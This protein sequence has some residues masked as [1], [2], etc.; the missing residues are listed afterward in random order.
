MK[1]V[2]LKIKNKINK[3]LS[4]YAALKEENLFLISEKNKLISEI[5]NCKEKIS[6][7]EDKIKIMSITKS[8][9]KDDEQI[10]S[11]RLKINEYVREIDKCIS[12]LNE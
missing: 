1:D 3:L 2:L 9:D 10:K 11:T 8:V 6:I 12:L 7:M 4:D 5:E